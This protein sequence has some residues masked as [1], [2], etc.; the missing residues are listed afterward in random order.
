MANLEAAVAFVRARADRPTLVRLA[1]ALGVRVSASELELFTAGQ[2]LG[3]GW[4]AWWSGGQ[5]SLDATCE[6]LTLLE[7]LGALEGLEAVRALGYVAASQRSDGSWAEPS[8]LVRD[9]PEHLRPEH[10]DSTAWLTANCAFWLAMGGAHPARVELAAVFL[11][12]LESPPLRVRWLTAA[13]LYRLGEAAASEAAI[14]L[15][16]SNQMLETPSGELAQA[17]KVLRIAGVPT[18]HPT[19][20]RARSL[21]GAAQRDDGSWAARNGALGDPLTTLEAIRALRLTEAA[22][23]PLEFASSGGVHPK[24]A[25]RPNLGATILAVRDLALAASFWK[26]LLGRNPVE[27]SADQLSFTF[28]GVR[29]MFRLEPGA[30]NGPGLILEVPEDDLNAMLE[31]AR[32]L[33]A[34]VVRNRFEDGRLLG[35]IFDDPQGVR[36]EL[37][38]TVD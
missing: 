35:V 36:F 26:G 25:L 37:A 4:P 32:A 1:A 17:L 9:G 30:S 31:R 21:L 29:L 14:N 12:S 22:G 7:A 13:A 8:P 38:R 28:D 15:V 27:Q 18:S 6:R 11:N 2:L 3:G 33:G 16:E 23:V 34:L 19:V 24:R 10:K 20:T 5:A